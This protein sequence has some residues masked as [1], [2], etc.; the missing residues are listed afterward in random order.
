MDIET[1]SPYERALSTGDREFR[2]L[3]DFAPVMIWRA[4]TDTLCDWFNQPWLDFTGR[5]LRDDVGNGWAECVHPEDLDDCMATFLGAFGAREPFAMEYRLRR[6][7]GE[8]RWIMDHGRPFYRDGHFAG[9]WGSCVDVSTHRE[10]QRAQRLLV[11]E[12]NHRVKNTLAVVQAMATQ[13]FREDRPVAES[14]AS[15]EG[16]LQALAAAHDMLVNQAWCEV[17]LRGVVEST[18]APHDPGG[19]RIVVDGPA[20]MLCPVSAVSVAMAVHE[21]LTNA[22][23]YGALSTDDGQVHLG[24]TFD[25]PSGRL[26]MAWKERGGPAVQ[27]PSRRGFGVR[28]IERSL[29]AQ[30]GGSAAVLFE[31]D[32][33]RCHFEA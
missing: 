4:G 29:A 16:R 33:V 13:S 23:K 9:Y 24:W 20:L 26:R 10:A 2:E 12:L 3:A 21:L 31:P 17:T 5:T 30:A 19:S 32:G 22:A 6:H 8:Y 15:F 18:V 25:R 14:L 1:T 7:D 27:A 11:N 28:F